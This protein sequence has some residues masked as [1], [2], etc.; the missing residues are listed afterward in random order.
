MVC[1]NSSGSPWGFTI[2]AVGMANLG[3][4]QS[5]RWL[6]RRWN[7]AFWWSHPTTILPQSESQEANEILEIHKDIICPKIKGYTQ[8][9]FLTNCCLPL[10]M[11]AAEK[12]PTCAS[13]LWLKASAHVSQMKL[14]TSVPYKRALRSVYLFDSFYTS[15]LA[16][17]QPKLS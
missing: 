12:R 8:S 13:C 11:E 4:K 16:F 3:R 14:L 15:F 5:E 10:M 6:W 7:K 2:F 9:S 1:S 17:I